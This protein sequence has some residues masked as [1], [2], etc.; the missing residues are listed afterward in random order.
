MSRA[1]VIRGEWILAP[2]DDEHAVVGSAWP[3]AECM[4][5]SLDFVEAGRPIPSWIRTITAAKE[6]TTNEGG[7]EHG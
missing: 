2:Q 3:L 5:L 7:A 4:E 1:P 6:D